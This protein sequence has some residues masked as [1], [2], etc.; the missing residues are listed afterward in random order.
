MPLVSTEREF[1]GAR[2]RYL[3]AITIVMPAGQLFAEVV[4]VA[5][6]TPQR[7]E[8]SQLE[9]EMEQ[10][11]RSLSPGEAVAIPVSGDI[12]IRFSAG[13]AK[14]DY[15][16]RA[17]SAYFFFRDKGSTVL[18]LRRIGLGELQYAEDSQRT[19]SVEGNLNKAASPPSTAPSVA[20]SDLVTVRVKLLV[21]EE[22]RGTRSHWEDRLKRRLLTASAL[23]ERAAR[24]RFELAGFDVWKSDDQI[25]DFELSLRDFERQ[26]AAEPA[27]LAIGFTSQYEIPKGRTMLGGTHGPLRSHILI[28]EW[29]QHVSEIERTEIL[30]HELAHFLGAV[31]S[32]ESDSVM[33]PVL[34]DRQARARQFRIQFDPLNLLAIGLVADELREQRPHSGSQIVESRRRKLADIYRVLAASM[35]DDPAAGD[36]LRLMLLPEPNTQRQPIASDGVNRVQNLNEAPMPVKPVVPP[37]AAADRDALTAASRAVLKAIVETAEAN[38]RRPADAQADDDERFRR[39]GDR[40]TEH[41]VRVAAS[42][43]IEQSAE[44]RRHAFLLA[45]AIAVDTSDWLRKVPVLGRLFREIEPDTQRTHRLKVLGEPTLRGRHDLAQH[46][47][48]SAAIAAGAGRFPAEAAGL[49]KEMRDSDGGSGFSF[50]DWAADLSGIAMAEAMADGKLS[51]SELSRRFRAADFLPTITDLTDGLSRAEFEKQFG[52]TADARFRR[53]DTDIRRRITELPAYR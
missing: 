43:A 21:D 13:D 40:L 8:F 22:E 42:A 18:D 36:Y 52:S 20:P 49:A 46:F 41:Y 35:P 16:L 11:N 47:F 30:V 32:P 12:R 19:P 26:A 4:V 34:G 37:P 23:F 31:H 15:S 17:N 5:N 10:A 44:Q 6:R 2:L 3:L 38:D 24:V 25:K 45:L 33:R 14:K 9:G 29:S 39:E 50:S 51:L 27:R 7:V 48:L 53:I 28:R 1:L